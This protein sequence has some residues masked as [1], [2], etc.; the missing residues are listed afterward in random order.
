MWEYKVA[1]YKCLYTP[2][3]NEQPLISF[4]ND[5]GINGWELVSTNYY[6]E[7]MPGPGV[8]PSYIDCVFKR[9]IENLN[10]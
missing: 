3:S 2:E 6:D 5:F 1:T 4:L 9:K 10:S 8:N 7:R